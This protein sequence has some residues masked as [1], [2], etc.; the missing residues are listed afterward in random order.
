MRLIKFFGIIGICVAAL[1][2]LLAQTST[3]PR[4]TKPSNNPPSL[5]NNNPPSLPNNNPP[6]LPSNTPPSLPSNN[7]PSLPNNN[8][9]S[10]PGSTLAPAGTPPIVTPAPTIPSLSAS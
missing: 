2:I 7:P 3:K 6:S 5:P 4:T 8:P 10:V 1:P 9:P